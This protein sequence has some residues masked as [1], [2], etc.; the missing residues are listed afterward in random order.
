MA[1]VNV[2]FWVS[3]DD[4]VIDKDTGGLVVY[5]DEADLDESFFGC[6]CPAPPL[7]P[8]NTENAVMPMGPST[9]RLPLL[10]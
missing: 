8:A 5:Q 7:S 1:A 4:A 10:G 6:S 3:P 2:N 9:F